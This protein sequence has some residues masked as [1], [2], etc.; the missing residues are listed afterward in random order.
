MNKFT[1]GPWQVH[2]YMTAVGPYNR[3]IDVGPSHLAVATVIGAF[4]QPEP[5]AEAQANAALIA[6]APDLA[7]ALEAANVALDHALRNVESMEKMLPLKAPA[8]ERQSLQT[9]AAGLRTARDDAAAA[10]VNATG[11]G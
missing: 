10:L 6:S 1:T 2:K 9:W 7:R 3:G 8:V 4:E 11:E 5:G